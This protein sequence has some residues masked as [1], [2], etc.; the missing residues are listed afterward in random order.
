MPIRLEVKNEL[1]IYNTR[2]LIR[3]LSR[4]NESFISVEIDGKEYVIDKIA[5]KPVHRNSFESYLVLKCRD[6]GCGEIKR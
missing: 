6:G 1:M 2:E 4:Q 5:H 3:E